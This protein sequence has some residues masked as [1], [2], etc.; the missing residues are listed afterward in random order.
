MQKYNIT[1]AIFLISTFLFFN[2][3]IVAQKATAA[4]KEVA[5]TPTSHINVTDLPEY[6]IVTCQNTKLFGGIG[7]FIDSNKSSY[8]E[9]LTSLENILQSKKQLF[10]R[11]QTDLLN[12]MSKL[13]FDFVNA[14][15][16][17]TV[18][19]LKD[20]ADFVDAVITDIDGSE[21]AYKVNMVFRKKE[22][23]RE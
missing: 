7:I 16:A 5:L 3:T 23:H 10:I 6:V 15:N 13:G 21:G 19:P 18:A 12:A 8:K 4:E 20:N 2:Q 22:K 1:M 11:N 9:E 17:S 14:Y